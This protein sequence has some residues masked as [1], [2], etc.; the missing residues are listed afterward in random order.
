M[1]KNGNHRF[2]ALLD[3]RNLTIEKLANETGLG[4]TTIWRALNNQRIG[5]ESR[6]ILCDYFGTT[7]PA[8][9]LVDSPGVEE[10]QTQKVS[11]NLHSAFLPALQAD[12]APSSPYAQQTTLSALPLGYGTFALSAPT[13]F[14]G[15]T[16]I[17]LAIGAGNIGY[18]LD[19][20][21]SIEMTLDALSIVLQSIQG[22]PPATRQRLLRPEAHILFPA[23]DA[24]DEERIQATNALGKSIEQGWK[25]FH[26]IRT[27]QLLAIAQAQ[28]FILQ[29]S[30]S[31]I[32]STVRPYFYS[33]VYR[34]LGAALF[35][36]ARYKEALE[37]HEKAYITGLEANDIWNIAESLSWQ[38]GVWKACGQQHRAIQATEAAL[39]LIDNRKEFHFDILRARLF[40]HVAESAALLSDPA[41][42]NAK[43]DVSAQILAGADSNDEF[44]LPTWMQYR[45][46]CSYYLGD[47]TKADQYFQEALKNLKSEWVLQRGYTML[48]QAQARLKL[49]EQEASILVAHS[50]LPL[51]IAIDSPLINRGLWDYVE[52]LIMRYPDNRGVKNFAEE[53]KQQMQLSVYSKVPRYLEAGI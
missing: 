52:E 17:W 14:E 6:Q 36:Q 20:G 11:S 42:T 16:G 31:L 44:D 9:G 4:Q 27:T 21:W 43:L 41:T 26:A 19:E 29:Q 47:M 1:S 22:M 39:R 35:F 10:G 8:L 49:N 2:R 50:A 5:A 53:V 51:I 37:A 12:T 3:E 33:N 46:I 30:H 23:N 38:G 7:A 25:L 13:L 24:T 48:L 45:A 28:L 18:L 34:L 15:Y 40:A 32:Y